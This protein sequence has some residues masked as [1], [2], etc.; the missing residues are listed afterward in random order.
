MKPFRGA[1]LAMLDSFRGNLLTAELPLRGSSSYWYATV[2]V[3]LIS[4]L[5]LVALF[6]P[7]FPFFE[8]SSTAYTMPLIPA[9]SF[10]TLLCITTFLT[11][12]FHRLKVNWGALSCSVGG[13]VLAQSLMLGILTLP[14]HAADT[15]EIV[16]A[17]L[18]MGFLVGIMWQ[19]VL[20]HHTLVVHLKCPPALSAVLAGP[21]NLAAFGHSV[22]LWYKVFAVD[23]LAWDSLFFA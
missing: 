20:L 10:V 4:S 17:L 5:V 11:I 21:I 3:L 7:L 9:A 22:Y 8:S 15:Q 19:A 1:M 6:A 18:G 2:A 14:F 23:S 12:P 16:L 13:L